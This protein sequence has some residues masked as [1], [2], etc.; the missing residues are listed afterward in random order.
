M[1][2]LSTPIR[3]EPRRVPTFAVTMIVTLFYIGVMVAL[4]AGSSSR[5]PTVDGAEATAVVAGP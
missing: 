2:Q 3:R 4:A 1:L 5:T